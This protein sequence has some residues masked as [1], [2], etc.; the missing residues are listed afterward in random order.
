MTTQITVT[1][2]KLTAWDGNVR[3]TGADQGI[4]ELASSIAAHGLLQ[5]LVVRKAKRG[6]YAV[7]AGGRRLAALQLLADQERI[8]P[9]HQVP[10][11][12]RESTGD[13]R[14][15]SLA[16][17]VIR[18]PMHPADQFEAYRAIIDDGATVPEVA[19]R[20]GVSESSVSKRLRLGRLSPV[21][22]TAYRDGQLDLAQTEAF[23]LSDDHD[24]QER[25]FAE[26]AGRHIA[27]FAIRRALTQGEI[28]ATDKR[29]QFIGLEAYEQAGGTIRRDLFDDQN[30]RYLQNPTLL[31][32]LVADKLRSL[33]PEIKAEGWAWTQ[34]LPDADYS[35]LSHFRRIHPDSGPLPDKNESELAALQAEYDT[36]S[37]SGDDED[38]DEDAVYERLAAIEERIDE[39]EESRPEVW[40][41]EQFAFAGVI[42]TLGHD[43][44]PDIHRGL[45]R[46]E[47]HRAAKRTEQAISGNDT[48]K[49]A[50]P[51][52][53]AALVQELTAQRTA[54]LSAMLANSP[55]IALAAIVHA[56]AGKVFY[57]YRGTTCLQ[58]TIS[59]A[60]PAASLPKTADQ[61]KALATLK[62]ER[63][64]WD[65]HLP[66][67]QDDLWNW[68][69]D[70]PEDVLLRLLAFCVACTVDAT[71]RKSDHELAD[72]LPHADA[73]AHALGLDMSAW[74]TP[75][76]QN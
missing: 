2:N 22:L 37:E 55:R 3:K 35:D 57:G 9:D 54:A 63:A 10:C 61:P 16:E 74:F 40:T 26:L 50:K 41:P 46:P 13:D 8:D 58:V 39:I 29:A 76:T 59:P 17:N 33:E 67:D 14:E 4:E 68:C 53:A 75:T 71:V 72:R 31:D 18:A 65:E 25:I 69:L 52:F 32:Q 49:P 12:L 24:A 47:D 5:P 11:T 34:V 15:I 70:Q 42:I 21:I 38:A 51:A 27:P 6:K 64:I 62:S 48:A 43:G 28:P 23:T 19:I 30:A 66:G 45:V 7:I 1:L 60:N 56:F 20:F 44:M 73:L 36:L